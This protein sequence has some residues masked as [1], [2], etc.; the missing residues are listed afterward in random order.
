MPPSLFTR[1]DT[2]SGGFYEL[3]LRLGARKHR[4]LGT[5]VR[6]AAAYPGI[7][8]WYARKDIEPSEQERVARTVADLS[9]RGHLYGVASIPGWPLLPVGCLAIRYGE[10]LG[11]WFHVYVPT[12]AL[13]QAD[14]RVG[15]FPFG[16]HG[17]SRSLAWRSS[18]DLW[19]ADLAR[20]IYSA[21]PF[22]F[23]MIGHEVPYLQQDVLESINALAVP[24]ER[25]EGWLVESDRT[26]QYYP[27]THGGGIALH[28]RPAPQELPRER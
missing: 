18:I 3:V 2:W 4:R 6:A 9:R 1:W 11:D 14:R 22:E 25:F 13:V 16:E 24:D 7:D 27:A 5:A 8:G 10:P 26:L 28:A 15:A 17:G 21:V 12:G 19:L 20:H 23:G